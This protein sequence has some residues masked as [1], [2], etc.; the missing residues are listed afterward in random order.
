[1]ENMSSVNNGSGCLYPLPTTI[2]NPEPTHRGKDDH[3]STSGL[4]QN[5]NTTH[6]VS[7]VTSPLTVDFDR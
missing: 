5:V 1:M 2:H 6:P 7:T 4:L 3:Q